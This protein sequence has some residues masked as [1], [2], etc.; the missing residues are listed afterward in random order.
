MRILIISDIHAN[1]WALRAV[2]EQAGPVDRVVFAGDA[3]NYGP[4][5]AG[6][7]FWLQSQ[8]AIGVRGDHDHAVAFSIDPKARPA[9]ETIAIA[10]RDWT[11]DR[12]EP[13]QNGWL[14]TLPRRLSGHV[15]GASFELVHATPADP[16]HDYRL[17]PSAD[18]AL[19]AELIAGVRSDVLIVGHTHLPL[20]RVHGS[21]TIINPGSVGQPLDGDPRASF[22]VW[23][24]GAIRLCRAAY[25][26]SPVIERMKS[27]P[28]REEQIQALTE[29]LRHGCITTQ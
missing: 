15:G 12:L 22:A 23:E 9:T 21:V 5:P 8:R 7:V 11:C 16:L 13:T 27:L 19:V 4:D 28:L 17:I 29:T 18:D 14:L 10:L 2:E 26:Q 1:S 3:V 24:D 25:D 6:V 20:L